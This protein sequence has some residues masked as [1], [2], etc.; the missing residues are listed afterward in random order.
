MSEITQTSCKSHK[1]GNPTLSDITWYFDKMSFYLSVAGTI[2]GVFPFDVAQ[3]LGITFSALSVKY[4]RIANFFEC[5]NT[6][7]K[8]TASELRLYF[9][10]L[11]TA[12]ENTTDTVIMK[13]RYRFTKDW[14]SRYI[15]VHQTYRSTDVTVYNDDIVTSYEHIGSS[16]SGKVYGIAT[17]DKLAELLK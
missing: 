6:K 17:M 5:I 8:A 4:T 2:M 16:M 14:F 3:I 13:I 9:T 10:S 12:M 1:N 15:D 11:N 7:F